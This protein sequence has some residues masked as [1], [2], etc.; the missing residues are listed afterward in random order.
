MI[1]L[2]I[3]LFTCHYAG[4]AYYSR[5]E[6]KCSGRE[7]MYQLITCQV[8]W[9]EEGERVPACV[10]GMAFVPIS[11]CCG[12]GDTCCLPRE[13][14]NC[15]ISVYLSWHYDAAFG[16][17]THL[18]FSEDPEVMELFNQGVGTASCGG[19]EWNH[20]SIAVILYSSPFLIYR[21]DYQQL[22][23]M[24]TRTQTCTC[25]HMSHQSQRSQ[26]FKAELASAWAQTI[27]L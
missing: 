1:C 12:S 26:T 6:M 16:R 19:G 21:C 14:P 18:L 23:S 4:P 25:K 9:L 17:M 20:K 13:G 8:W 5:L 15:L 10:S 7:Q 27:I 22:V 3:C 24:L 2:C 11:G